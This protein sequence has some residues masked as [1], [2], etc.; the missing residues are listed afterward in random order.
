MTKLAENGV[1]EKKK[2]IGKTST[3]N[4]KGYKYCRTHLERKEALSAKKKKK[5]LWGII[6]FK[7]VLKLFRFARRLL[8]YQNYIEVAFLRHF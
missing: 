8:F 7:C 2:S 1:K 4:T 3:S 6:I 5:K